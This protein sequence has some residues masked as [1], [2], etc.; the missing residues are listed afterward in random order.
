MEVLEE[1]IKN[2]FRS[3]YGQCIEDVAHSVFHI[4]CEDKSIDKS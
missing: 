4:S 1:R 2:L 3:K